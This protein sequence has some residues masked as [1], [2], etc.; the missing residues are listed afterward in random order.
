MASVNQTRGLHGRDAARNARP[1]CPHP[2]PHGGHHEHHRTHHRH[3]HP[4]PRDA[5]DR[6]EARGRDP[7]GLRRRA[8]Q[9]VLRVAGMARGRGLRL[10]RGLPGPAVHASRLRG[11][12]HLRH[13]RHERR[14]RVGRKPAARRR[15]HR[16]G[17]RRAD[18]ARRRRVRGLPRRGVQ[19]GRRA[20]RARPGP[21][22]QV[23]Q[24]VRV[25]QRSRRERVPA[26]GGHLPS[27]GPG[28]RDARRHAGRAPARDGAAPR[29]LREGRAG[30][31][32]GGTGT[33]RT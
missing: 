8:H 7:S 17:A 6:H 23:L 26:A 29:P 30:R 24:L 16:G 28:G 4:G 27:A 2:N 1:C 18:R 32:T 3:R 19:R 25:V 33:R 5:S 20:S 15:R 14:P 13:R 22:A 11:V 31:T 10:H 9:A 21:R 12:A